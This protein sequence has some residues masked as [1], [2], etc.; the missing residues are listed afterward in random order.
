MD[1]GYK[2]YSDAFRFGT[3]VVHCL[4]GYFFPDIYVQHIIHHVESC[5]FK[6]RM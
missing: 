4:G 1:P 2:I 5:L 6:N 3:Y